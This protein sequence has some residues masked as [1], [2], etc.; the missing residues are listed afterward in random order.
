M[1]E[2]CQE[3]LNCTCQPEERKH[4]ELLKQLQATAESLRPPTLWPDWQDHLAPAPIKQRHEANLEGCTKRTPLATQAHAETT[5]AAT[6][7]DSLGDSTA[8]RIEALRS[9]ILRKRQEKLEREPFV[10]TE[11]AS[12]VIA[13]Q[14]PAGFHAIH[15]VAAAQRMP[16]P[17]CPTACMTLAPSTL[18]LPLQPSPL[19]R[20]PQLQ[21][22]H[23]ILAHRTGGQA[24]SDHNPFGQFPM[25]DSSNSQHIPTFA[26][27][28]MSATLPKAES[29]ER[30]TFDSFNSPP[31]SDVRAMQ[32][33]TQWS[34]PSQGAGSF[35][36]STGSASPFREKS[37]ANTV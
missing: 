32:S 5:D 36:P 18:P 25:I 19:Q 24:A 7:N 1:Q 16:V 14:S 8:E 37:Q 10:G 35:A 15:V 34:C 2:L 20:Q 6:G 29:D 3:L 17:S 9:K 27:H 4:A 30:Q 11:V 13:P 33:A 21:H 12:G 28:D 22:Q 26:P 23:H 31:T